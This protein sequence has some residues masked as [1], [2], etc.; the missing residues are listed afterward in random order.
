MSLYNMLH[1]TDPLAA[2]LLQ[3]LRFSPATVARF[4]DC[5]LSGDGQRIILLTRTGGGN[6]ASFPAWWELI[7]EHPEYISDRDDDFDSTFAI[8]E[9]HVPKFALA[10]IQPLA[11]GQDP[12]TL[13]E[14]TESA[15]KDLEGKTPDQIRTD[16]RTA[17]IAEILDRVAKWRGWS[18]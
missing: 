5:H 13:R 16:P 14:K 15:I 18:V 7:R 4:R 1:G 3:V 17:K 11:T 6:R 9:F 10:E 8:T 12:P 2:L